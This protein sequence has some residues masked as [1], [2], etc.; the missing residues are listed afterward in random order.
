M[1]LSYTA[2]VAPFD[3]DGHTDAEIATAMAASRLTVRDVP[4]STLYM[5]LT[6]E[7]GLLT[8]DPVTLQRSGPLVD[9]YQHAQTPDELKAGIRTLFAIL[10]PD[11]SRVVATSQVSA[12]AQ[13]LFAVALALQLSEDRLTVLATLHGGERY[14]TV[15]E[16]DVTAAKATYASNVARAAISATLNEATAAASTAFADGGTEQEIRAAFDAAW[17][18]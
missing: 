17:E 18:E 9:L 12:H 4:A 2:D 6:V 15:T 7:W 11:T 3:V 13:L 5:L 10:G 16:A 1:S 8:V 14:A